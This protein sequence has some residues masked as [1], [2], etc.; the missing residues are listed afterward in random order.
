MLLVELGGLVVVLFEQL[1]IHGIFTESYE[2][3]P[4]VV[5]IVVE[6]D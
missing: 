3:E 2:A 6:P 4:P 1:A 5:V